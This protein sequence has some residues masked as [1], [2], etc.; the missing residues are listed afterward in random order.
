[1]VYWKDGRP[2]HSNRVVVGS[3]ENQTPSLEKPFASVVANPPWYVPAGIA[4]R[5]ILPK[6]PAYLASQNMYISERS[7]DP[8]RRTDRPPSAM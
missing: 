1:M 2:V 5:E 3:A 8:A 4:R 6:G 7:G